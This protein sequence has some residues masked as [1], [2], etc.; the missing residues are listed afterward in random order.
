LRVDKI[1]PSEVKP[2]A[3]VR[4]KAIA[5]WQ[6]DKRR[7]T[8]TKEAADLAAAV[9]PDTRLAALAAEKGLKAATSPPFTRQPGRD[10]TVP[11]PLVPKLFA[12]K[13]GE[14]VTA[15]DPTGAYV[16]QLDDVQTPESI[17]QTA[18]S[19]LSHELDTGVRAALGEEFTRSLRA[20]FPVDI[21]RE[22]LDRLF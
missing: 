8:V 16:A 11:Q 7:E 2:L 14:A 21:H 6:A 12:A 22:T 4:E 9:K 3:E 5:A 19:V 1:V 10:D 20:R 13:P 18:T 17:S 15:A